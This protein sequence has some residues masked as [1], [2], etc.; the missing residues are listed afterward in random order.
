MTYA[1]V[2]ALREASDQAAIDAR[3]AR[4]AAEAAQNPSDRDFAERAAFNADQRS[5]AARYT[6]LGAS[7]DWLAKCDAPSADHLAK[8]DGFPA[9]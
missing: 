8:E 9:A 4:A 7:A 5:A 3:H 2:N 1:R 6:Y